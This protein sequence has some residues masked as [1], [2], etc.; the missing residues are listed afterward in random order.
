M[1]CLSLKHL[2]AISKSS[3]AQRTRP[4]NYNGDGDIRR[5]VLM[6]IRQDKGEGRIGKCERRS[7]DKTVMKNDEKRY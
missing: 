5:K 6:L 7:E 2:G 1:T 3:P 4:K